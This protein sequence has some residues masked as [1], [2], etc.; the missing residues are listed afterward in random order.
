MTN[1]EIF[2]QNINIAY[3]LTQQYKNCGIEYDDLKQICL[4]ALWKAVITYKNDKGWAFSTYSYKVIQNELNYY[5][6]QNRKYFINRYFSEETGENIT[7]EDMIEDKYN[8]IEELEDNLDNEF[9]I[10]KIKSSLLKVNERKT[11][12]LYLKGYK[13]DKIAK[14]IGCSQPQV[15]RYIKNIRRYICN[16]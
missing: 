13:Q 15:S 12:E 2:N 10:N 11:F 9:L 5:L 6:R 1:E 14:I 7:L 16:N 4:L 3:K 8:R